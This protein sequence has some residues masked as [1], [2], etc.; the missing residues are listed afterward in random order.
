MQVLGMVG[1]QVLKAENK[2]TGLVSAQT[3]Y[4]T[5]HLFTG[6]AFEDF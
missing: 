6:R 1:R 2:N 4:K 3:S 5:A